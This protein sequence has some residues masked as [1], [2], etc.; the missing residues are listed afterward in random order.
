MLLGLV[1][2]GLSIALLARPEPPRNHRKL[3]TINLGIMFVLVGV[4]STLKFV[5]DQA[6]KANNPT[7]SAATDR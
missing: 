3:L 5:R 1:A 4:A 7:K 2:I 6:V